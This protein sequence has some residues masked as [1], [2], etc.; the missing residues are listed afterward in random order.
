MSE[1]FEY[2]MIHEVKAESDSDGKMR[3]SGYLA[4]FGNVDSY[5]DVIIEGA[6]SKT[7]R[8]HKREGRIVPVLEQHGGWGVGAMDMTPI[9]YYESLKEDSKG[10]WVEGVLF[11]TYRGQNMH[12]L[13]KEAPKGAM[14]QSIGYRVMKERTPDERETRK[15]GVMRYLEELKL[16]EGSIVT[17]PANEKARVEDVKA[18]SLFWRQLEDAFKKDGFSRDQAK[19]AV[20]L[21]KASTPDN[22]FG[23]FL[24]RYG[25]IP[26]AREDTFIPDQIME[27]AEQLLDVFRQAKNEHDIRS[28]KSIFNDFTL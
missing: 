17:F 18:A 22:A 24:A 7:L 3:F 16:Y 11:S 2:K 9:G 27:G 14:G 6:F 20:S 26:E 12:T 15:T 19:K 23:Q 25:N 21:V 1:K 28:F 13:L 5:G 10:L 8:E 4:Y